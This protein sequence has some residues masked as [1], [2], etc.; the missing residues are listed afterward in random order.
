M[1]ITICGIEVARTKRAKEKE[2]HLGFL[3]CFIIRRNRQSG[4]IFPLEMPTWKF[5][6]RFLRDQRRK[7]DIYH[8]VQNY[9]DFDHSPRS[10]SV[11]GTETVQ[12]F[13]IRQEEEKEED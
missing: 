6:C 3:F 5:H 13:I 8:A 11:P 4:L 1:T 2:T 7:P 12:L 9:C 10:M